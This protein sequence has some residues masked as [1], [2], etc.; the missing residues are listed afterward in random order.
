VL[1]AKRDFVQSSQGYFNLSF[2]EGLDG[3][4]IADALRL[5]IT[6]TILAPAGP[7]KARLMTVLYNDIRTKSL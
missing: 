6:C 3:D 5:A 2:Q 1:D 7:R 4:E